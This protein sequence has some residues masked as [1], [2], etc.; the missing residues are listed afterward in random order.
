MCLI[1]KEWL[2]EPQTVFCSK[3]QF[4]G[5]YEDSSQ[6]SCSGA[7]IERYLGGRMKRENAFPFKTCCLCSV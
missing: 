1:K 6:G 4:D 2:L 3:R 7:E 5:Y